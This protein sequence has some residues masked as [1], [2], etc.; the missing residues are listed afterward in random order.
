MG[1]PVGALKTET[2]GDLGY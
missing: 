1:R 2:L